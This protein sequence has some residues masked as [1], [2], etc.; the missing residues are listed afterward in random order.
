[1]GKITLFHALIKK[2]EVKTM[3]FWACMVNS[4]YSPFDNLH[5][6]FF[7]CFGKNMGTIFSLPHLLKGQTTHH[8]SP[9]T[10]VLYSQP[11]IIHFRPFSLLLFFYVFLKSL[12]GYHS[13]TKIMNMLL[14]MDEYYLFMHFYFILFYFYLQWH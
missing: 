12:H 6:L 3:L 13:N 9:L 14:F 7:M 8:S 10:C 2:R 4:T 1:L 11:K 5:D